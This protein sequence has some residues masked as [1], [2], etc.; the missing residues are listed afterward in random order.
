[1]GDCVTV[2]MPKLLDAMMATPV[3]RASAKPPLAPL[4]MPKQILT[5]EAGM[6]R[7]GFAAVVARLMPKRL[8][9]RRAD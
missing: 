2:Q 3:L 4:A 7:R 8:G 9:L 6:L 5:P 1:M